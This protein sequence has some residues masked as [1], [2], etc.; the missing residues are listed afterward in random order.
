MRLL[1]LPLLLFLTISLNAQDSDRISKCFINGDAKKLASHFNESV[2]MNLPGNS[3]IY[4]KEQAKVILNKF[5]ASNTISEYE[6]KHKGG[7]K[8]KSKFHIGKLE[9]D[10]GTFRTYLLYN[11]VDGVMQIIE[12]RIEEE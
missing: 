8:Q 2:E 5:F 7:S 11:N 6:I 3:G 10:K 4:Q 12:I 1:L 9:T